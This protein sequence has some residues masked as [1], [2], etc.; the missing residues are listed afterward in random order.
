MLHLAVGSFVERPGRWAAVG[1]LG[2][3]CSW[4]LAWTTRWIAEQMVTQWPVYYYVSATAFWQAAGLLP[5]ALTGFVVAL[6]RQRP[7]AAALAVLAA[8]LLVIGV[9]EPILL[10]IVDPRPRR[11][12]A[13]FAMR[14]IGALAF[15]GP[16]VVAGAVAG[17]KLTGRRHAA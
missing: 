10:A 9:I 5:L 13:F 1:M 7:M 6:S 15:W 14:A 3:L 12:P 8:M 16:A 17:R 11:T 2:L 4:P